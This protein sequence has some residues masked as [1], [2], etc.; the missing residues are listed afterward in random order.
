MVAFPNCKINLGLRVTGKRPD[1]FHNIETIFYP[2]PLKDALEIIKANAFELN[3]SGIS[4][5]GDT[6][7]NLCR[8]AYELIKADF[9]AIPPVKIFLHKAIPIGGGLGGGSSNGAFTLMLLN[10]EFKLNIPSTKLIEY[11]LQ[12][13]S[14]CPFF[15]TN[16]PCFATGRGEEMKEINLDLGD[17]HFI[18]VDSGV[19]I[20]TGWAFGELTHKPHEAGEIERVVSLPL[21][22]WKER[23][24][25][26]FEEPVFKAHPSIKNI[27][28]E[29]YKAGAIYASLTGTGGSVYGI[30]NK[31]IKGLK[32]DKE[33][34]VHYLNQNR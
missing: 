7:T 3:L 25:N 34:K 1:G 6:S 16:K 29:L 22:T 4:I 26:D 31:K 13:G 24:V 18:L 23:L 27:K 15:I 17:Y 8:K 2:L 20:N 19:H 28:G 14:D 33:Y 30:F 9:P 10:K 11:A 21:E 12:L 32:L 5:P